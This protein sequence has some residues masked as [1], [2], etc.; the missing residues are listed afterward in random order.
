MWQRQVVLVVGYFIA[1]LGGGAELAC[2]GDDAAAAETMP[3][4]MYMGALRTLDV[5]VGEETIPFIFD[6]AGGL[7]FVTPQFA[8]RYGCRPFGR[9]VGFRMSGEQLAS[10]RCGPMTFG[11]GG[12]QFIAETEVL[13]IMALL[14]EG[15]PEV[16]GII[17]LHTFHDSAITIELAANRVIVETDETLAQRIA[18]MHSLNTRFNTQGGGESLDLFVE[19]AAEKGSLWLEVDSG[20]IGPVVLAQH[21]FDQLGKTPPQAGGTQIEMEMTLVGLDPIPVVVTEREIIYD[22][23]VNARLLEGLVLTV[24]LRTGRTWALPVPKKQEEIK[25]N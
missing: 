24:D 18:A 21:A 14:P 20:N 1:A 13:D 22:G 16:G 2:A 9:V 8:N 11:V 7:T 5:T 23:A 4:E 10:P 25:T 15:W 6:T 3:L 12:R 17:S 19:A